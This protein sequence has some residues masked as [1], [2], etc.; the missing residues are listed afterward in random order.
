MMRKRSSRTR[1]RASILLRVGPAQ[2]S[3]AQGVF[4]GGS[5]FPR[6]D[7]KSV[8]RLHVFAVE[9]TTR[10]MTELG[11][12]LRDPQRNPV[13]Q[14]TDIGQRDLR[15]QRRGECDSNGA[16]ENSRN[17]T[18]RHLEFGTELRI[19]DDVKLADRGARGGVC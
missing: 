2:R 16:T 6:I 8:Q 3:V 11:V 4:E 19:H 5:R 14:R 9:R 10:G 13:T 1:L 18:V 7:S 12:D 15:L 17:I